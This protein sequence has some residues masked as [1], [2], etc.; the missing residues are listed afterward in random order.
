MQQSNLN[1]PRQYLLDLIKSQPEN[2][3]I[4]LFE[5]LLVSFDTK[6]LNEEERILIAKAEQ[7]YKDGKTI[8]F[9]SINAL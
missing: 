3:I 7:E 1:I 9:F 8:S 5:E 6:P 4:D 2:V